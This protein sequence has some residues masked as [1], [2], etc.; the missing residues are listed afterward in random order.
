LNS[1]ELVIFTDLDGTFLDPYTYSYDASLAT[2][3]KLQSLRIPLI[4]CSSKTR[5]EIEPLWRELDLRDPFIVE[6]GGAVYFQ[7]DYFPFPVENSK[8]RDEFHVLELGERVDVMRRALRDAE[9]N[10][11]VQLRWF[12][13]MSTKEISQLT[14]LPRENAKAASE[15][16]YDE[17]FIVNQINYGRLFTALRTKGFKI[18]QGDRFF[19]LSRGSDKGKAT[20]RVVELYQ[21]V[22]SSVQ[23][24]GLGN[25]ANDLLMLREVN[26]AILIRKPDRSWD[27]VVTQNLPGIQKT[28]AIGPEGWSEAIEE[29]LRAEAP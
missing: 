3:R 7:S 4:F 21:R 23:S 28:M 26:K 20:R 5:N 27:S 12:G 19:H 9:Q 24:V 8:M 25:A 15:R 11:H 29:M 22:H 6:N 18:T 10:F 17:P 13:E 16:E 14:G 2:F 1:T